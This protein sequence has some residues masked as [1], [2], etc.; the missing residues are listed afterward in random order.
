MS[1]MKRLSDQVRKDEAFMASPYQDTEKLW[2]FAEGRCLETHPLTGEEWKYL[3]DRQL[4]CVVI[5]PVGSDWLK[6][7]ELLAIERQLTRDYSDFWSK[8]ND[9]RQ[10]ALIEMAYQMGVVKEEAFHDMI[11]AIRAAIIVDQITLGNWD[12]VERA[13]LASRWAQQTPNRARLIMRQLATGEF[14]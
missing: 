2:T 12:L 6:I 1:D 11:T 4:L 7:Q 14:P 3:L 10:N 5:S 8:L 9:A 13:G